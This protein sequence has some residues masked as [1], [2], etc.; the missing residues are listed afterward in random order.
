MWARRDKK[1]YIYIVSRHRPESFTL[2]YADKTNIWDPLTKPYLLP[3]EL[4]NRIGTDYRAQSLVDLGQEMLDQAT[5]TGKDADDKYIKAWQLKIMAG[6]IAAGLKCEPTAV[7]NILHLA[8]E[9]ERKTKEDSHV[10]MKLHALIDYLTHIATT[11][12]G[13][14]APQNS[15]A[16]KTQKF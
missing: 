5:G 15:G 13:D 14:Q 9:A 16:S 12:A 7:E 2:H 8:R 3:E 1:T 11:S 4:K 6:V 10:R